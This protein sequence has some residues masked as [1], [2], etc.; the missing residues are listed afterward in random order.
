MR[1]QS[2]ARNMRPTCQTS[3]C[4]ESQK[5]NKP[6]FVSRAAEDVVDF[7]GDLEPAF[8]LLAGIGGMG[9]ALTTYGMSS[10]LALSAGVGCFG[11]L[12]GTMV[13]LAGS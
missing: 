9:G 1:I 12:A 5:E 8:V 6:S 7:V 2:T 10:N 11:A 13:F 3:N 4:Q